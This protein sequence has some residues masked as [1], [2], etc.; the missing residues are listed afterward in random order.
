MI[1]GATNK[2]GDVFNI[3]P[4]FLPGSNLLDNLTNLNE[5]I[6]IWK[7]LFNSLFIA[8]TYTLIGM[9]LCASAGYAFAKFDFKGRNVI[10]IVL[11]LSMMIPY[12]AT[13]IP[14][15]QLFAKL[16]WMNTYSAVILPQ[17]V[18]VFPIFL[19]RQNMKALP[20]SLLE[21]ARIDS[22]GEFYIFFRIA[23][24]TMKPALAAVAIFLFNHQWNNFMWPLVVMNTKDMFT[25]PVALSTLAGQDSIDYGQAM[26][27]TTISVLPVIVI[28]LF[29]Q[30]HF[31]SGI[32]GGAVKG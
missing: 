9:L 13:I 15:F 6:L 18:Y 4:T 17:L 32:L 26:L 21:A 31:V 20:D 10:F 29:M 1:I 16:D 5:S 30:K 3:P 2:S 25:L 14:L 11:L 8:I 22:A 27:G 24:P 7:S 19:M 28:F 23:L 12:Q